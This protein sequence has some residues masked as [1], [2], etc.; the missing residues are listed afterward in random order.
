MT[1]ENESYV[2]EHINSLKGKILHTL[3]QGKPFTIDYLHSNIILITTSTKASRNVPLEGTIDAY[4]HIKKHGKLTQAEIRDNN[5][6]NWNPAYI[7]AILACFPEI[8][9]KTK[10]ITLYLKQKD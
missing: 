2:K 1:K 7:A 9:H 10:P 6:S 5:Y 8:K 4:N 3:S